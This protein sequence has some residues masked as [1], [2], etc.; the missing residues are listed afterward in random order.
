MDPEKPSD[1]QLMAEAEKAVE[2]LKEIEN[3]PKWEEFS[4]KPCTM[5]KMSIEG[6]V[7]SRGEVKVAIPIKE[8]F[9]Q[10]AI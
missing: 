4:N 1:E 6:R 7:A 5:L 3:N 9:D 8:L 2:M 10:L